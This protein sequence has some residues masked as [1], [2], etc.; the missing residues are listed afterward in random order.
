MKT[1]REIATE[2]IAYLRKYGLTITTGWQVNGQPPADV[3][4]YLD[5]VIEG[6][7]PTDEA[8]LEDQ[9]I[10]WIEIEFPNATISEGVK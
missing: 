7:F 3:R 5:G 9:V 2:A 10:D 1:E 8:E 6:C 4:E